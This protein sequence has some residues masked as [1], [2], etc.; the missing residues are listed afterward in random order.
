[1]TRIEL[2]E[3]VLKRLRLSFSVGQMKLA[4]ESIDSALEIFAERDAKPGVAPYR[5]NDKSVQ[6]LDRLVRQKMAQTTYR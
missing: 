6:W 4:E 5:F 1:M 2:R 3:Q